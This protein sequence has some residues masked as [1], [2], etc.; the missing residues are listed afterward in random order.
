MCKEIGVDPLASKK[1][2]WDQMLGVADFYYELA[3]QVVNICIATRK[4]NGGFLEES[5]CL[6]LLKKMRKSSQKE[7]STKDLERAIEELK[8]LGSEFRMIQTGNKKVICSVSIELTQDHMVLMNLAEENGGWITF[9][10]TRSKL[11]QFSQKDRFLKSINFLLKE[12]MA[13]EDAEPFFDASNSKGKY[14]REVED[15]GKCYWFPAVM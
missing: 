4:F 6:R 1:G 14:S 11:P 13:W 10:L 9:S 7:V 12:G 3:I 2:F 15:N 5:D 8:D